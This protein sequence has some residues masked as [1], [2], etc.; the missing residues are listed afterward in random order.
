MNVYKFFKIILYIF[1]S[2]AD[3]DPESYKIPFVM[4]SLSSLSTEVHSLLQLHDG[5]L[6]LLR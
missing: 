6:P 5:T 3:F 1:N 2:E 4:T